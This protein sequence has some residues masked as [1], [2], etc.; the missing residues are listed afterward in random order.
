[1]SGKIQGRSRYDFR[2]EFPTQSLQKRLIVHDL[3][4]CDQGPHRLDQRPQSRPRSV[5]GD[6]DG[7]FGS[8]GAQYLSNPSTGRTLWTMFDEHP[9]PVRP[10]LL[11]DLPKIQTLVDRAAMRKMMGIRACS[12]VGFLYV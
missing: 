1:M 2:C 12:N 8:F 11:D 6:D 4:R 7:V 10:G 5:E 3:S 9:N